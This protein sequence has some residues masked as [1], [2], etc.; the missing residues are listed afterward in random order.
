MPKVYLNID[1]IIYL[2]KYIF[3]LLHFYINMQK[4]FDI[5]KQICILPNNFKESGYVVSSEIFRNIVHQLHRN[6]WSL[7]SLKPIPNVC[8]G[9]RDLDNLYL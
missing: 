7:G 6:D 5:K 8:R 4:H 2:Y 1:A 3:I 9:I